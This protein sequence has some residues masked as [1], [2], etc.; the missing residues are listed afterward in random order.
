[1]VGRGGLGERAKVN[2]RARSKARRGLPGGVFKVEE[3]ISCSG[4]ARSA[5]WRLPRL[6]CRAGGLLNQRHVPRADSRRQRPPGNASPSFLYV[7]F[8]RFHERLTC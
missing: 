6:G 3:V 4:L 2:D 8:S 7:A 5:G 1:M